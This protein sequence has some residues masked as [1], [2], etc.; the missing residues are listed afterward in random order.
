MQLSGLRDTQL[1]TQPGSMRAQGMEGQKLVFIYPILSY[2]T[3]SPNLQNTIRDFFTTNF[4]CQIKETNMF[5]ITTDSIKNVGLIGSGSSAINPA[6]L[7]R[8]SLY[9]DQHYQRNP[10]DSWANSEYRNLYQDKIQAHYRFIQNQIVHD[11]RYSKM[12][13]VISNITSENLLQIPLILGTKQYTINPIILYYIL[14]ISATFNIPIKSSNNLSAIFNILERIPPENYVNLIFDETYRT[15]LLTT[16]GIVRQDDPSFIQTTGSSFSELRQSRNR[17]PASTRVSHIGR[18]VYK[19]NNQERHKFLSIM[20]S[21]V[22]KA[23]I[24]F[25]LVLNASRWSIESNGIETRHGLTLN[26]ISINTAI[27]TKYYASAINSFSSYLR[28][29]IIPLFN[30]IELITGPTPAD[31][32]VSVKI[33]SFLKDIFVGMDDD[34]RAIAESIVVYI[35]NQ[36]TLNITD[37]KRNTK[38]VLDICEQNIKMTGDIKKTLNEL[39]D[40]SNIPPNF[41]SALLSKFIK[42]IILTARVLSS[43]EKVINEWFNLMTVVSPTGVP[44]TVQLNTRIRIINEKIEKLVHK[45]FFEEY[46]GIGNKVWIDYKDDPNNLKHLFERFATFFAHFA[47]KRAKP[48]PATPGAALMNLF[49]KEV[50]YEDPNQQEISQTINF[51]KTIMNDIETSISIIIIFLLKWNFFSYICDYIKEV[52]VDIDIQQRDALDFPNYCLVLPLEIFY[53]LHNAL[54]INHFSTILRDVNGVVNNIQEL[55]FAKQ[56]SDDIPKMIKY[57]CNRLSIPNII[58]VDSAAK[59]IHYKFM[60]MTKSINLTISTLE[61]YISHQKEVLIGGL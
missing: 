48:N 9:H 19:L 22:E 12:R 56:P 28:A 1:L 17:T 51:L 27:S 49:T 37:I 4:V 44:T 61:Q 14:L 11:P 23:R 3:L 54:S 53:G 15:R 20:N 2:D 40:V 25:D 31:V 45:L 59:K 5:N 55:N 58:L 24:F 34:F 21:E 6:E 57:I 29:S 26:S 47:P 18:L 36:A 46:P 30:S 16:I 7:V 42:Q 50:E 41:E 52:D 13:P 39:D 32:H 38:S 8:N 35:R 43:H 60:Y 33:E 10:I